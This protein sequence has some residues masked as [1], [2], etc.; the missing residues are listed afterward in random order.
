M[1][2]YI[3]ARLLRGA[4]IVWL[5]TVVVFLLIHIAPGD[6]ILILKGQAEIP[7][8][9]LDLMRAKWGLNQPLPVQYAAW[10]KNLLTGDFG[11]SITY[12]GLQVS[13]LIFNTLPNTVA[14]NA[15]A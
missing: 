9:Q 12:G 8:Q 10:M 4:L 11:R 3:G 1:I 6:P 7:P 15:I 2:G 5:I 13:H 14:L